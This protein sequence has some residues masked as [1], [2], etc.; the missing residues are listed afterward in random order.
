MKRLRVGAEG[1]NLLGEGGG[2][3]QCQIL[4]FGEF[5]KNN[6]LTMNLSLQFVGARYGS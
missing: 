5:H 2:G 1:G 3:A 4:R 6:Y